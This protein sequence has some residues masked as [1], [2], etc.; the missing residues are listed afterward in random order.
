MNASAPLNIKSMRSQEKQQLPT[1]GEEASH[2]EPAVL[3]LMNTQNV[4][5]ALELAKVSKAKQ[6]SCSSEEQIKVGGRQVEAE[7]YALGD[8][9]QD[10]VEAADEEINK[11]YQQNFVRDHSLQSREETKLESYGDR[12]LIETQPVNYF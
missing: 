4:R 6:I 10:L 3:R 9:Q 8:L 1:Y 7:A 11:L 2:N 5:G 12:K